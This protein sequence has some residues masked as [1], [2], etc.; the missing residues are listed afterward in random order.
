[1]V[2][3]GKEI[4]RFTGH[5]WAVLSAA[6]LPD[7][8]GSRIIT[9]SED[10]TAKVWK[11][12]TQELLLTL[13]GHTATVSSVAFLPDALLPAEQ[14]PAGARTGIRVL[15]GSLDNTAKLWDGVTGKEILTLK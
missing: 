7:A 8:T 15:T 13:E 5:K 12:D 9:G 2:D 1:E 14:A 4:G 11:T 6:F 3:S 10:N